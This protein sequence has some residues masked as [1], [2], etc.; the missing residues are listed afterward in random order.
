MGVRLLAHHGWL[1]NRRIK[2]FGKS[3]ILL[4]DSPLHILCKFKK[5]FEDLSGGVTTP[6]Y[7][8]C[9]PR[10]SDWHLEV[11]YVWYIC[12][13]RRRLSDMK[14]NQGNFFQCVATFE[15]VLSVKLSAFFDWIFWNF[16]KI[17]CRC[18][19][20]KT[21]EWANGLTKYFEQNCKTDFMKEFKF[22]NNWEM[23][24]FIELET[25]IRWKS[26]NFQRMEI[27]WNCRWREYY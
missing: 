2:P 3:F 17:K 14:G 19:Q 24:K 4:L 11:R 9:S 12:T 10:F 15:C 5:N 7:R 23:I 1:P 8:Y 21:Q 16:I 26:V 22:L 13:C 6:G 20:N 27:S 25:K 18:I